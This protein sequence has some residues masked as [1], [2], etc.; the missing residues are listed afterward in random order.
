MKPHIWYSNFTKS[1]VCGLLEDFGDITLFGLGGSPKEA[2]E[3][4]EKLKR[5]GSE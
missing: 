1:W 4:Y 3:R 2:Y 5:G